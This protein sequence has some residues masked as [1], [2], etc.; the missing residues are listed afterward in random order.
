MNTLNSNENISVDII[1]SKT[2]QLAKQHKFLWIRGTSD[3]EISHLI[4]KVCDQL[5]R[6]TKLNICFVD[7]KFAGESLLDYLKGEETEWLNIRESEILFI[8]NI[9]YLCGKTTTQDKFSNL[10]STRISEGKQTIISSMCG[11][12]ELSVLSENLFEKLELINI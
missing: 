9:D 4:K 5:K 2:T 6:K 10:F 12:E 11:P 1:L 8:K 3:N 7:A